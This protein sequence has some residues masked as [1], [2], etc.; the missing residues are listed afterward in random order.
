MTAPNKITPQDLGQGLVTWFSVD[1]NGTLVDHI[2]ENPSPMEFVG[3]ERVLV[4]NADG[5]RQWIYVNVEDG[6]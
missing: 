3:W 6:A 1:A 5:S 4:I 2:L